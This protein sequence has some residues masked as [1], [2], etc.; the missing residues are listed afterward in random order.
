MQEN[1]NKLQII[2]YR[3]GNEVTNLISPDQCKFLVM[4]EGMQS[5]FRIVVKIRL[6]FGQPGRMG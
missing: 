5:K 1:I 2:R 6:L 4:S 3:K